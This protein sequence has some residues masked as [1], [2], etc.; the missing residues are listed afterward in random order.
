M[1]VSDFIKKCLRIPK[2]I[3]M[4]FWNILL[5]VKNI[6]GN[7]RRVRREFGWKYTF[8]LYRDKVKMKL[9][10]PF[11]LP[12]FIEK[13]LRS[14]SYKGVYV[15]PTI[16]WE[17]PIFQRPH[18]MA[19]AFLNMGYLVIYLEGPGPVYPAGSIR[20]P[21]KG[22]H[23]VTVLDY[24]KA[25]Q[26]VS[27]CIISFYSTSFTEYAATILTPEYR[28]R[29]QIVYEYIDHFD[30]SISGEGTATLKGGY[31]LI[32][33]MDDVYFLASAR[34]LQDD[35]AKKS[36]KSVMYVANGVDME[37]YSAE[38]I[39]AIQK[40]NTLPDV[41]K[42]NRV[43]IGYFG[44]MALWLDY[45]M[46]N[47]VM[48][49][50]PE[51][52]FI[53]IGPDYYGGINRLDRS[54]PNCHYIGPVEYKLLPGY[55]SCFDVTILPF[56]RGDLAKSTSPLKLFEYFALGKAVVVTPDL[57]ECIGH[58]GVFVAGD[59]A[60]FAGAIEKALAVKDDPD[61]VSGQMKTAADNSWMSRAQELEKGLTV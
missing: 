38:N 31:E 61:F 29:N 33:A 24:A 23:V 39:S 44:A 49:N 25:L 13:E 50:H 22:L 18:Q 53:F 4:F 16:W 10:K 59:A 26:N 55:A 47:T 15:I 48:K 46:I 3:L 30:E 19:L 2:R 14:G 54:L 8:R 35:L 52:D 41:F 60:A 58:P 40:N 20:S 57:L 17:T 27:G 45:E 56:E 43:K 51:W 9:R 21:K 36:G 7:F 32:T 11:S 12:D 42:S 34:C 37:H 5:R 6:I 1:S 28:R